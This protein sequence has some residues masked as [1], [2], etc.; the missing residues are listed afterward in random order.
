[1]KK[2]RVKYI[3]FEDENTR[4]LTGAK[5]GQSNSK[6]HTWGIYAY[7]KGVHFEE[8]DKKFEASRGGSHGVGKIASNAASDLHVMFFANCDE[9]NEQHL[10]GTI[11]LIEHELNGQCYRSSGYFAKQKVAGKTTKFMPFE[12][13]FGNVF[14]KKTR[15]LKIVIPFL[16]E[17]FYR[18][19]EVVQ[20]VCD[21]FFMAILERK[22]VV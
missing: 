14:E 2:E 5:Y 19:K 21:S 9:N 17:Q 22:L 8:G 7:N 20:A 16:R 11:Q 18:E 15:G 12:N 1:M 10:G 6:E 3:S 13:T 4:G